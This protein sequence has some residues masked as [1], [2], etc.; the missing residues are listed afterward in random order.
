MKIIEKIITF[1]MAVSLSMFLIR[2]I[3]LPGQVGKSE[4]NEL[5]LAE[6]KLKVFEGIREGRVEPVKA[7]TS[8][9]LRYTMSA[10]IQSDDLSE[11]EENQ[12][13]RVFNLKAVRLLTEASL[14]WLRTGARAFHIFRLDTKEYV[15]IITLLRIDGPQ[16]IYGRVEVME[17]SGDM[18]FNL[19]DS[20]L[21]LYRN[22][23]TTLGFEDRSGKPYFLS[24]RVH[25]VRPP[26]AGFMPVTGDR[27]EITR[28]AA[29][30]AGMTGGVV[31]EALKDAVKA[32][33]EIK[34]P[35][36]IKK[37]DPVY[38]EEAMK[39]RIEGIVI[40][41]VTTDHSGR[42]ADIKVLKSVPQLD[43][44]AIEAVR[45]WVYEPVIIDGKPRPVV[46]TVTVSFRL[47]D[48]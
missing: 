1:L 6:L 17:Q 10:S 44:A 4:K 16:R 21:S 34:P 41:E 28:E 27:S 30:T 9:F 15:V 38:P 32:T 40:L 42:V 13:Q 19:L 39:E 8:S 23:I 43:Q 3:D 22:V 31:P 46:F 26:N 33:G 24:L 35:K 7:V 5:P 11:K 12:I 18:K 25:E 45:Q 36:L 20:E 14:N 48:R 29:V 47:R 37:V 2:G